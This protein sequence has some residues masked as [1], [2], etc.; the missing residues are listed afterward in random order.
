MASSDSE[1]DSQQKGL[2]LGKRGDSHKTLPHHDSLRELELQEA[3]A[4][5]EAKRKS[6]YL[7]NSNT[8]GSEGIKSG[9]MDEKP[10]PG[11]LTHSNEH[12]GADASAKKDEK[13]K[14]AIVAVKEI[15]LDEN[16]KEEINK[17]QMDPEMH[18]IQEKED[19][20]QKKK[21]KRKKKKKKAVVE[22]KAPRR[23]YFNDL[24]RN[25]AFKYL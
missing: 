13:K 12:S 6:K 4:D 11:P 22:D 21:E 18:R 24:A 5:R 1:G 3:R 19:K 7:G 16:D 15:T 25:A 8:G 14:G 20:K 23:I 10:T 17:I 9:S 2:K